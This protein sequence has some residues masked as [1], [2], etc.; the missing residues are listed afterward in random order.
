MMLGTLNLILA[1]AAGAAAPNM[2]QNPT[3]QLLGPVGM[4]ILMVVMFYF[5]LIG[6]QRKKAKEHTTLLQGLRPGDKIVTNGGV[7][8]TVVSVKERTIAMRSA[9]TKLEIL[10][11][12]IAE[13][14]ERGDSG[15]S[16]SSASKS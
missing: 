14:T 2:Q 11:S 7:V 15:S 5:V 12:A 6:P 16:E 9:E 3:A 4:I 13:V 10:K 1:D 8:G